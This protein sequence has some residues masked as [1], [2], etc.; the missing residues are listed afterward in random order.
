MILIVDDKEENLFSLKSLL[1]LHGYEVDTANSGEEALKKI[2]KNEYALIILDV[3]MPGMDGYEVAETIT[4]YS[5]SKNI[6]I[7][8]CPQ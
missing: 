4:G 7:I 3:Q 6:P 5:K 8:F 2:L 1:R